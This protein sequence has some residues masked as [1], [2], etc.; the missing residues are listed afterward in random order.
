MDDDEQGASRKAALKYAGPR[1]DGK[2]ESFIE[3]KAEL[4]NAMGPMAMA[5]ARSDVSFPRPSNVHSGLSVKDAIAFVNG[6]TLT[7]QDGNE[8]VTN[9]AE[10]AAARDFLKTKTVNG[11][12]T[13]AAGSMHDTLR[14]CV[15]V[16]DSARAAAELRSEGKA[17]AAKTRRRDARR[18]KANTLGPSSSSSSGG[19]DDGDGG[20]GQ[21]VRGKAGDTFYGV[22]FGHNGTP[23]PHALGRPRRL[24]RGGL[25]CQGEAHRR[26]VHLQALQRRE[27]ALHGEHLRTR[28]HPRTEVGTW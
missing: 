22:R 21:A 10:L 19:D 2:E 16:L 27:R 8:I 14:K 3:A 20:A 6:V 9:H 24:R 15:Q 25:R 18:A 17:L 7:D 1:S 12:V 13:R 11:D 5:L 4:E 28:Q 26:Q 23:G